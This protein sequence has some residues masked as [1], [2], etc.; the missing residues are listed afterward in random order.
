MPKSQLPLPP[1]TPLPQRET[2]LR[3]LLRRQIR[4][5][6]MLVV[7]LVACGIF[8]T[9]LKPLWSRQAWLESLFVA[10]GALLCG[11]PLLRDVGRNWSWRI[12]LGIAYLNAEQLADAEALLAPLNKIQAQLFDPGGNGAR[13][14]ATL[15][16][17]SQE[18]AKH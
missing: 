17:K 15:N 11:V 8:L 9:L 4:A 14:L 10:L 3:E 13:A 18:S 12:G 16:E 1:R 7:R 5:V 6:V 2:A